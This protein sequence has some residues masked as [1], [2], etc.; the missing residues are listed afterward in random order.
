MSSY[1]KS[2]SIKDSAKNWEKKPAI[3]PSQHVFQSTLDGK[4]SMSE[5]S[6]LPLN[7]VEQ[8]CRVD[9][10]QALHEIFQALHVAHSFYSF[11][12]TQVSSKRFRLMF[13]NCPIALVYALADAKIRYNLQFGIVPHCK[14][15]HIY[16]V[17]RCPFTFNFD[18][19]TNR[20]VD[21]QYDGYVQHW[22]ESEHKVLNRYCSSLFLWYCTSGDLVD[23]FKQFVVDS[24]L[25]LNYLLHL[26][27]DGP[28][29]NLA[30][31]EKLFKHLRDNLDNAFL[32]R[33]MLFTPCGYYFPSGNN[34]CVFR[35]RS[36][37]HRDSVFLQTVKYST[38][39]LSKSPLFNE[40][41][42]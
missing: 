36:V 39:R 4:I 20:L 9:I 37:F 8:L 10:F 15:Q 1:H 24:E 23:H 17:K 31:Q 42:I 28:N 2:H 29:V 38:G 33:Y 12:S 25:D 3:D 14:E 26:S 13:P 41:F 40:H 32:S 34:K 27:M 21:K 35:S 6:S 18:E 7:H 30:F 19:S 22:S 11:D 5:K 16:D